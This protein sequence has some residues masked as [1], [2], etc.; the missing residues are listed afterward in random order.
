[1][2]H[3][4]SGRAGARPRALAC[5]ASSPTCP[6]AANSE[7]RTRL[8][9]EPSENP[10]RRESPI[11]APARWTVGSWDRPIRPRSAIVRPASCDPPRPRDWPVETGSPI[12]PAASPAASDTPT[13]DLRSAHR[14]L[15]TRI[16][17]RGA[18]PGIDGR[19]AELRGRSDREGTPMPARAPMPVRGSA[20][21]SWARGSA[22]RTRPLAGTDG[23]GERPRLAVRPATGVGPAGVRGWRFPDPC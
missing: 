6:L 10:F 20:N 11:G 5:V 13:V 21:S 4:G 8:P 12:S 22:R 23:S 9:E 17:P 3:A 18:A 19:G 2:T 16:L 14:K 7:E 1:M 15:A